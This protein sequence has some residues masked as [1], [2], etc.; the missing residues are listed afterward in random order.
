MSKIAPKTAD[1]MTRPKEFAALFQPINSPLRFPIFDN[2]AWSSGLYSAKQ[3]K[4]SMMRS[5]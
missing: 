5:A 3:A 1:P 4:K 2:I